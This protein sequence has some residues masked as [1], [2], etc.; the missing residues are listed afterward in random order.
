MALSIT[1]AVTVAVA[2]IVA[3]GSLE[4][5]M[6]GRDVSLNTFSLFT[7]S[8]KRA[9]RAARIFVHFFLVRTLRKPTK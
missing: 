2:V 1:F 8:D 9:T 6:T 3:K 5:T 7:E 4:D